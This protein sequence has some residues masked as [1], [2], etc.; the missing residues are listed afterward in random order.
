MSFLVNLTKINLDQ[1]RKAWTTN[2]ACDS[3][4]RISEIHTNEYK[5][6]N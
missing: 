2:R 1:N 4:F 6:F 5:E 3:I